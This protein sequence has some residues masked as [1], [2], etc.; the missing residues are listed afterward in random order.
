[1]AD[2]ET[3]LPRRACRPDW[4]QNPETDNGHAHDWHMVIIESYPGNTEA[5]T[6]CR[7]CTAPRCGSTFDDDPCL[8]R[9]HH[10]DP[11]VYESG[12]VRPVG[13]GL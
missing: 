8:S 4:E 13:G 3:T 11:H 10:R 2:F 12:R 9:R 1:M 6:V 5:M 7:V